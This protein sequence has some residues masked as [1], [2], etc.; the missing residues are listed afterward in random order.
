MQRTLL[1]LALSI[2]AAAAQTPSVTRM[3]ADLEALCSPKMEGRVSLGPGA[4]LAANY[5]AE[6]FR[7]AGLTPI[8]AGDSFLQ[9]FLLTAYT[10]DPKATRLTLKADNKLDRAL[11]LNKD[12]RGAF[13]NPVHVIAPVVFAGYGITAPEYH[14]DDYAI[15]NVAGKAVLIFEHEPQ[16]NDPK[17][18]FNGTGHTRHGVL[19][20]KVEN[21]RRHGALAVIVVSEPNRKH[22]GLFD[23][24]A[25]SST[26]T[27]RANA[28]RQAL[29][30]HSLPIFQVSD[31][32]ATVIMESAG[33]TLA[34]LQNAIDVDLKPQSAVIPSLTVDLA[35]APMS[36]SRGE[37]SNV[38][39]FLE[40]SDPKLKQD[41]LILTAHYDH[42]G[43]QQ[44][45]LYPGA[46]DNASG[47]VAVIELAR[48]FASARPHPSRSLLFVV[49]GSEEELMLGSYYYTAHPL[50][51][52]ATTRAVLNLDMIA[53]D[54]AHIPQS[55]GVVDIPADTR[56]EINLI[57]TFYSPELLHVIE[58]ANKKVRL[59][60]STKFDRD[61][62]LNALFRCDHLPFLQEQIPTVWFFGGWHPGY[63]EPSDVIESL[64]FDKLR[65]VT[66]LA[67]ETTVALAFAATTPVW[68]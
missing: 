39:G 55:V 4:A 58:R 43:V 11:E 21:A 50:R 46:N 42:L 38:V 17:S 49:F 37:S 19:A 32:A 57:G 68:K 41:T 27:L 36:A 12:F 14:Y 66:E 24:P 51:P 56:N 60:L 33:F 30:Q 15:I 7:A 16:E 45:H 62:D 5:I 48:M 34:E 8:A 9:K 25:A 64:N 23:A 22:R 67:R 54:E 20:S 40:G 52:L 47:T 13:S 35:T 29:E 53:R 3:R 63:H 10:P 2:A 1:I 65:K 28:P 59:E 61:H 6:Q 31:S 18:I 26:P 44:G